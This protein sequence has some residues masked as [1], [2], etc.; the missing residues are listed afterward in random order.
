MNKLSKIILITAAFIIFAVVLIKSISKEDDWICDGGLWVKH[1]N[2]K[3][4]API[5]ECP[6]EN[7]EAADKN[8]IVT[9]P[10]DNTSVSSSFIL[11]GQARVFENQFSYRLKDISGKVI[12]SGQITSNASEM[13]QYGSFSKTINFIKPTAGKGTLEVFDNSAKD[14]GEIDLV[15]IP[16]SFK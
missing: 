15:I 5:T 13:G 3:D 2:P 9:E 10:K 1:G 14:G 8:I 4:P 12:A 6:S 16:L 11:S 7:K